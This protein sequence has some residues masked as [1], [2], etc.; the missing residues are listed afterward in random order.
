MRQIARRKQLQIIIDSGAIS[1]FMSKDLNSP[2]E[3]ASYKT[4]FLPDNRQ[5]RKSNKTKLP[6]DKLSD[7]AQEADILPGLKKSLLSVNKMPEEGYTTVFHPGDEGVIICKQESI[8]IS[9]SQPPVFQWCKSNTRKLWTVLAER[10]EE[11]QEETHNVYSLPSI[12]QT[13]CRPN[14]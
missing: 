3:G 14:I 13:L 5:L 12:P 1:H 8:T 4:V 10:H 7:T 9:T 11:I 2:K 6:F